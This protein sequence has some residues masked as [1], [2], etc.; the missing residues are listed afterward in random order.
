M[1]SD[2]RLFIEKWDDL[3]GIM[4]ELRS[5][6]LNNKAKQASRDMSKDECLAAEVDWTIAE[7][8]YNLIMEDK[9]YQKLL[10]NIMGFSVD[11]KNEK[12]QEARCRMF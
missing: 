7:T 6:E 3:F 8:F 10:L 5:E 9:K 1:E 12:Y 11:R 2:F 4:R